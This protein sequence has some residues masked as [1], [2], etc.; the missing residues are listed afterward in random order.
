[1]MCTAK[2]PIHPRMWLNTGGSPSLLLS[3]GWVALHASTSVR[4]DLEIAN[5]R[6][7]R[8]IDRGRKGTGPEKT[9]SKE[10]RAEI[11]LE[12][13]LILPGLIKSHDHLEFNLFP[14]LGQGPDPKF[15]KWADDI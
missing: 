10:Q 8:L 9:N 7:L 11:S 1:M 2:N 5:G 13:C 12:G 3:G 6:I 15:G 14:R 4:A